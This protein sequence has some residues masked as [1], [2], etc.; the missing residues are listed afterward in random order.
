MCPRVQGGS[1]G[2][3]VTADPAGV[4]PDVEGAAPTGVRRIGIVGRD[5]SESLE[6]ALRRVE[7]YCSA[8]SIELMFEPAWLPAARGE[9]RALDPEDPPDL[10]LSL[11]G[12]GTLLR[13]ARIV[14]AAGVPVL[15]INLGRLGFLTSASEDRLEWAL[16]R[17][18][19][20]ECAFDERATLEAS[21][22]RADGSLEAPE[23]ALNDF[24]VHSGGLARTI[25][26]DVSI[27]REGIEEEIGSFS[28]DGVI[29]ATPTGSTAYS[30]SAGGPLIVP[31]LDAI[32]V[33]PISPHTLALRPLVLPGTEK[34]VI[35]AHDRE[36][37]LVLTGDGQV[38]VPLGDRDEVTVGTGP[39][40]VKLV[41]LPGSTFVSTLRGKLNWAAGRRTD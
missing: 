36:S 38:A 9:A 29:L 6:S 8:R 10:L 27:L 16:D 30:L 2:E 23:F 39:T 7:D 3:R 21:V 11:G 40:R 12:D 25:H 26:L 35:R 31:S 5:G 19:A 18:I 20:G 37:S 1:E 22:R 4:G 14:A 28:G 33:T 17:V 24:V 34:V 15:G 41:R 13:G 32:A